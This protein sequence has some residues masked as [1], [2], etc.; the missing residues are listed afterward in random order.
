MALK[1]ATWQRPILLR[2]MHIAVDQKSVRM[3]LKCIANRADVLQKCYI[4]FSVV[5]EP[6]GTYIYFVLGHGDSNDVQPGIGK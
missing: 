3:A 1:W 4:Y 5:R 2:I 6:D